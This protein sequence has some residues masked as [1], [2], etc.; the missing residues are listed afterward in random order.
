MY[1]DGIYGGAVYYLFNHEDPGLFFFSFPFPSFSLFD[2]LLAVF[3]FLV[4]YPVTLV[5]VFFFFFFRWVNLR[6]TFFTL[7]LAPVFA[8]LALRCFG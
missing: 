1:E 7:C 3:F 2:T 6:P 8:G 5:Y 4:S